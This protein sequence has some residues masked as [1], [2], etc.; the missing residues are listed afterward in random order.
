MYG[1]Y[2][3]R[4]LVAAAIALP[5]DLVTGLLVLSLLPA[6]FTFEMAAP[7]LALPLTN[8]ERR[9]IM[10]RLVNLGLLS[11]NASLQLFTMHK[12][13]RDAARLLVHN[14]GEALRFSLACVRE[15]SLTCVFAVLRAAVVLH[16][17]ASCS[18]LSP[19]CVCV[20]ADG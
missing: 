16:L 3:R 7:L 20:W 17:R 4:V 10:R 14:L 8:N 5:D 2:A 15:F 13:V 9:A 19:P 6:P 18:S 12:L 11:Y 1:V